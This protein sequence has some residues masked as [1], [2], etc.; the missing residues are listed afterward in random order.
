VKIV[1]KTGTTKP[2]EITRNKLRFL[3]VGFGAF[4][5]LLTSLIFFGC[6]DLRKPEIKQFYGE[7]KPPAKK[8]FRWANGK[9]PKQLD[10][11]LA[12]APPETDLVRAVY[13]GLTDLDPKTLEVKPAVAESW[14]VSA[15]GRT[16]TFHLRADAKWSN[17]RMVTARDFKR[18]WRRLAEMGTDVPN[19]RLLKNIVGAENFSIDDGIT[20]LP[21]EEFDV[22]KPE[23][24]QSPAAPGPDAA[25]NKD[26]ESQTEKASPAAPAVSAG[27]APPAEQQAEIA[28][29]KTPVKSSSVN[30]WLGVEAVDDQTLRV[31]L[32]Q[33]DRNFPA[34]AAN[35][36]FRPVYEDDAG[37]RAIA[38]AA[39]AVT[40]GAF[41]IAS[42]GKEQVE[43]SR[44]D[45]FWGNENTSLDKIF[46]IAK[47]DAESALAA[48]QANE[49]DAITNTH[50]E[51]L[52]L[53][54]LAPYRDFRHTTH[55]ALTFYEFNTGRKPFDDL[56]VRKALSM[57]L[58][59]ARI[60]QDELDG[61]GEPAFDYL[62][63]AGDESE[64]LAEDA[65]EAKRLLKEAGFA[66]GG[67]FPAIR[68]L[69]NRNDL[70]RR[71]AQSIA[72]MWLKNFGIP[73][74][75]VIK[76]R[77]EYEEAIKS[78]D[79]DIVRRGVVMPTND[80]TTGMLTLFTANHGHFDAPLNSW[81]DERDR[82]LLKRL[83]EFNN[84]TNVALA[85]PTPAADPSRRPGTEIGSFQGAG[86]NDTGSAR[87]F[88]T[89]KEALEQIPAIPLYFAVSNSLV[90]P[91]VNGFDTNLLDAPSLK[92]TVI[93]DNWKNS[94]AQK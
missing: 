87:V 60:V 33:P 52:A 76:D 81:Q 80:E 57:M 55:N 3:L 31:W 67:S 26:G 7:I 63:F 9:L 88:L 71:I 20:V 91:Y 48:Y 79:Y 24:A 2:H 83:E 1:D 32:I 22:S 34:A 58:D 30:K 14:E 64:K 38:G 42:V 37:L 27:L 15:D 47:P 65:S 56:R 4:L 49:I 86:E 21:D 72:R 69:I 51:P 19:S 94:P 82:E 12:S 16:W 25:P 29:K 50:F 90:K 54:L 13:E 39:N 10:P 36:L 89:E 78:G 73:T 53:K 41:R 45:L 70:Q 46:M 74:E 92:T 35:P 77:A 18:S 85:T 84:P 28:P 44:S 11:A 43:L 23:A 75:I 6:A 61:A 68:L 40:N 59:R 5:C 93:D 66:D 17:G 8:E 62:P